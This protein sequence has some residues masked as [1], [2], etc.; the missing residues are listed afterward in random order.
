MSVSQT[1]FKIEIERIVDTLSEIDSTAQVTIYA[2]GRCR[3]KTRVHDSEYMTIKELADFLG[4][5]RDDHEPTTPPTRKTTLE[6]RVETFL[7]QGLVNRAHQF[8]RS[9]MLP[10]T[11]ERLLKMV[12]DYKP[13]EPPPPAPKQEPSEFGK[14]QYQDGL[15]EGD[16]CICTGPTRKVNTDCE[17]CM[18]AYNDYLS[19]QD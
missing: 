11:R 4:Q 3:L 13:P 19:S 10:T 15:Y 12:A 18:N 1:H 9:A 6:K 2:T 17:A 8:A 7:E 5:D 14:T 16:P